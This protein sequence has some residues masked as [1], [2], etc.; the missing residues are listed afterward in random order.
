MVGISLED[1]FLLL[2][3][4]EG[5]LEEVVVATFPFVDVDVDVV[6]VGVEEDDDEI[7]PPLEPALPPPSLVYRFSSYTK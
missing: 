6:G 3:T 7:G 1:G 2:P 5:I 4:P